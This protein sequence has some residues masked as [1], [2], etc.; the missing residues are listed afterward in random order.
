MR[1]TI[2]SL[3]T[4][5]LFVAAAGAAAMP[6][7]AGASGTLAM[8]SRPATLTTLSPAKGDDVSLSASYSGIRKQDTVRVQIL[9][10]QDIGVVYGDAVT[11]TGTPQT[12]S[13][14]LGANSATATSI[15]NAGNA[16]CV[17]Y[18]F[19][20]TNIGGGNSQQL[21]SVAFDATG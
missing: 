17:G 12:V 20:I 6:K 14:K 8:S 10:Y 16:H 15:W 21:A 7:S 2:V 3:A 5:A 19:Y 4:L 1:K 11:L 18:L 9:C 13:F